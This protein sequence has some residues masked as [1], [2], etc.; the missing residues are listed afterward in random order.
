MLL[1]THY[2]DEAEKLSDRVCVLDRGIIRLVDTPENLMNSHG[3][4]NLEEVFIALMNEADEEAK[5]G[6]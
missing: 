1:T 6:S 4:A 5:Q 3:K 2:L